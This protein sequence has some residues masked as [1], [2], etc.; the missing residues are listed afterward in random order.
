M[1]QKF[2]S[3]GA[4]E[5]SHIGTTLIKYCI[6]K[7]QYHIG[8]KMFF[9]T[10]NITEGISHFFQNPGT[11]KNKKACSTGLYWFWI[12]GNMFVFHPTMVV[13]AIPVMILMPKHG[14]P[15][16]AFLRAE[17]NMRT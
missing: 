7:D 14:F 8:A 16:K 11:S 6:L 15:D 12:T 5:T 1:V 10:F 9:I 4:V 13:E 17:K 2:Q 3:L